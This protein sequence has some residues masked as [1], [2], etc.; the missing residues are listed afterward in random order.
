MK[1]QITISRLTIIF[2]ALILLFAGILVAFTVQTIGTR[3]DGRPGKILDG[4]FYYFNGFAIYRYDPVAN[5]RERLVAFWQ[6]ALTE[7]PRRIFGTRDP[8][9][10]IP[11]T[12]NESGIFYTYG[13][14]TYLRPHGANRSRSLGESDE[15]PLASQTEPRDV[16]HLLPTGAV[17]VGYPRLYG[18]NWL[19]QYE[20]APGAQ[21]SSGWLLEKPGGYVVSLPVGNFLT[22]MQDALF[23]YSL[24]GLYIFDVPSVETRQLQY[25]IS[26]YRAVTDGTW[27]FTGDP[28]RY[29]STT[30]WRLVFDGAGS[31]VGL[32][33][34]AANI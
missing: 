29:Q 31:V 20:V 34:L 8:R 9:P 22:G 11:W 21:V 24:G 27:L 19:I 5:E 12:V 7:S 28:W 2:I 4:Q 26:I 13:V 30:A 16:S 15:N 23:F 25:G 18:E 10:G 3:A 1:R 14:R 6:S 32:E 17:L 33:Q